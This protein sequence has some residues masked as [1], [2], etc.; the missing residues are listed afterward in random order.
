MLYEASQH[1]F[2]DVEETR[3]FRA[4]LDEVKQWHK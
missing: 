1:T 3:R 4:M 2:S